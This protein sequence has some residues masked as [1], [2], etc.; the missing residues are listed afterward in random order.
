MKP[1]SEK[2]YVEQAL[3]NG[4]GVTWLDDCRIP[5]K[6]ENDKE[7][8]KT[9]QGK[10]NNTG[11]YGG[12]KGLHEGLGFSQGNPQ[13]RFPANLLVSDNVLDVGKKTKSSGGITKA[14]NTNVVYGKFDKD[15]YTVCPDDE[16]DFSRYFSLDAWEAQ[17]IITPKPSKSEKNEGLEQ[18]LSNQDKYQGKFPCSKKLSPQKV[19]DGRKNP[20]DNPFQRGQT[21]R[22]N[23]HPTVKPLKLMS[24][25]ITLGSRPDDVVLDPFAG[26][27]TT[28]L[29]AKQIGR[30]YIGIERE[31]EY[32]KICCIRVGFIPNKEYTKKDIIKELPIKSNDYICDIC[33]FKTIDE[34]QFKSHFDRQFHKDSV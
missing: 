28:L 25:L 30:K 26:S 34:N 14:G 12:G 21:V 5:Y 29:S 2:N 24:Y 15:V 20:P 33:D 4:K 3:S 17:F 32:Y 27:G 19:N 6:N 18:Y 7:S 10:S 23:I 16:G 1:L 13:G 22:Q 9:I 31:E 11:I 8:V